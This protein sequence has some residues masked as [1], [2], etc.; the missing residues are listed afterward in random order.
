MSTFVFA[1]WAIRRP[2]EL[3]NSTAGAAL[4]IL[5]FEPQ[6]LFQASFQLSFA[7][8]AAIA[9]I[10]GQSRE[11]ESWTVRVGNVVHDIIS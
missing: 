4:L 2:M 5:L 6:Q 8:V 1:G 11:G 9:L 7:V 10:L 3:L